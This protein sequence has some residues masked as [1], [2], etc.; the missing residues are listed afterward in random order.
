MFNFIFS[1]IGKGQANSKSILNEKVQGVQE[2]LR[3]YRGTHKTIQAKIET[4]FKFK[5]RLR[6]NFWGLEIFKIFIFIYLFFSLT[7]VRHRHVN[8]NQPKSESA[9]VVTRIA[10]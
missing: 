9:R 6:P 2:N 3:F 5:L 10:T 8:G 7:R 4:A 1:T